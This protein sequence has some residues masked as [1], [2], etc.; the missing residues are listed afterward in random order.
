MGVTG[1]APRCVGDRTACASDRLG[2][3][4]AAAVRTLL[5]TVLFWAYFALC[6]PFFFAIALPL[7][8][9][10]LPFDRNG[11]ILHAFTC[12]WGGHYVFLNPMWRLHIE[13]RER[14]DRNKAYVFCS[15]H[16][17]AGDIPVLFGLF[18]PFKFVSKSSNFK[19]PFLGWNMAMN[20]YVPLVRGNRESVKKMMTTCRAWL[21]RGV[22]VLM[23]P[24]GTR[25]KTGN[26]LPFKPGAFTLAKEAGVPVVP[27]VISG[28]IEAVPPDAILRQ[29]GIVHVHVRVCEPMQPG[30]YP[31]ALAFQASVRAVMERTLGE[32]Q[33]TR[34]GAAVPLDVEPE[35]EPQAE[36]TADSVLG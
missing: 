4:V 19:A 10:T 30:A 28:T 27:I 1:A 8:L 24:E 17:S 23:F 34:R 22:S 36:P 21:D 9:V 12:F 15:S 32:L 31:D 13:G 6:M 35:S 16:Q 18:L 33:T 14:V 3:K 26:L 20:R 11:R 7:W 25:S 5:H 29:R 2:R